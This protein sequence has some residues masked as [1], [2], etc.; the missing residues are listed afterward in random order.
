MVVAGDD[1]YEL[2]G[3]GAGAPAYGG[4]A[5]YGSGVAYGTG[6]AY[7]GG[8]EYGGEDAYQGH[9]P[10]LQ[11]WLF[12]RR[13][14][15]LVA[16][17]VAVI[18][19]GFTGWWLTSGRYAPLPS[20]DGM[21]VA[22][23]TQALRQAGFAV[24]ADPPVIDNSVP[25]GDVISTS[26]SGRALKGATIVLTVSA[27]PRMIVVPPVAGESV[28]AAKATLRNAGLMVSDTTKPVGV[29]GAVVL[30]S[31]AGT[32]PAAG[33]SWPANRVVYVDVVAGMALPDFVGQDINT[34]QGWAGSNNI[35]LN[36]VQE[37]SSQQQGII[38]RQSP[39]PGTPVSAGQAVTVYV[40]NGPAEVAI[41]DLRGENFDRAKHELRQLGFQVV[42]RQFGPGD[43]VFLVTPS[44]SAP[45][46]SEITVYYGGL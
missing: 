5:G 29:A 32:T 26:P 18:G 30:G 9:E 2:A 22:A 24:R 4:G 36:P 7:G 19:L 35:Q 28:D 27:G 39:A 41:P 10:F 16:A 15:Y 44:G 1:R 12:S 25:K 38:V 14:A 42:G 21:R 31:V 23:A 8:A 11:R 17:A 20:V 46:G 33:T 40:S 43:T 34:I 37:A 45:S 3:Y 13:L 6:V